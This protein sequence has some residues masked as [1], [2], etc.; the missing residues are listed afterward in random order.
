MRDFTGTKFMSTYRN[1][2]FRFFVFGFEVKI[3]FFLQTEWTMDSSPTWLI[4]E[5]PEMTKSSQLHR[6]K[7]KIAWTRSVHYLFL[8]T[9][10]GT[11]GCLR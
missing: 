7:C 8:L 4:M 11:L 2:N 3:V 1:R 9:R 10:V 6:V 5:L